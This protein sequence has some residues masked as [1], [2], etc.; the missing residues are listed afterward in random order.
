M[1]ILKIAG[2]LTAAILV[3]LLIAYAGYVMELSVLAVQLT[4]VPIGAV[5]GVFVAVAAIS[6]IEG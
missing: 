1:K 2:L 3:V 6:V 4:L 5:L